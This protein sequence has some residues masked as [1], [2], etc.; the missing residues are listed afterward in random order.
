MKQEPRAYGGI[1]GF[2]LKVARQSIPVSQEA[3][4]ETLAVDPTTVQ[5]WESGRRPLGAATMTQVRRLGRQLLRLGVDSELVAMIPVAIEAD[6]I[7]TAIATPVPDGELGQHP[8][9]GCVMDLRISELLTWALTGVPP[10]IASRIPPVRRRGPAPTR[11]ELGWIDRK[12]LNANLLQLSDRGEQDGSTLLL[13]SQACF[14]TGLARLDTPAKLST[15]AS[16]YLVGGESW[17]PSWL[18][19]RSHV[20]SCAYRGDPEPL[21]RFIT[22]AQE[23]DDCE[24]AALNYTAYWVGDMPDREGDDGF[25]PRNL[26]RWRGSRM[27]PH[28]VERLQTTHPLIDLNTHNLWLL[29]RSQRGLIIDDKQTSLLLLDRIDE[30]ADSN[31]VSQ[32][33]LRELR[34]MKSAL[35]ELGY[36]K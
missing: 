21:R 25:M 10:R 5:S 11:P 23:S 31:R 8:L 33:S 28:L 13:R 6:L 32:Q 20:V 34:S 7:I 27:Y 4:A 35:A 30:A 9:A 17:S 1:S 16:R 18:D 2:M 26:L 15:A 29:L 14:L 3:F 22:H 12:Q 24:T 19:A 36:R